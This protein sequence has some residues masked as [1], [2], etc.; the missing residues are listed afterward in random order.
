MSEIELCPM[1]PE[2]DAI[3]EVL[4]KVARR[5]GTIS[6]TDL[7]SQSKVKLDM[8]I[9]YDRGI[10]G[11][12]LGEIS[13]NEVMQQRPM[14]SSVAIHAGDYKQG[15]GFFDLAE[16]LYNLTFNN[17]DQQLKFGMEELN[18]THSFWSKTKS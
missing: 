11:H 4:I 3:R 8:S 1:T 12:L 5:K 15:Q 9:P 14:L 6:Y 17:S 2:H 7:M 16:R 13:W 10:L 18:K